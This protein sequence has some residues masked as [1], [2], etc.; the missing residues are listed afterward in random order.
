V[1]IVDPPVQLQAEDL[2]MAQVEELLVLLLVHVVLARQL[3]GLTG[4]SSARERRVS[5]TQRSSNLVQV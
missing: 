4:G 1:Y 3:D 2:S 5:V